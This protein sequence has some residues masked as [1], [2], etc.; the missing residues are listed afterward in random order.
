MEGQ[1]DVLINRALAGL[2]GSGSRSVG[3]VESSSVTVVMTALPVPWY[4]TPYL[5]EKGDWFLAHGV[6]ISNI[7]LDDF[8]EGLL[9]TLAGAKGRVC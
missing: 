6:C 3:C 1:L 4:P 5:A 9:H 7:C 8:L 2:V